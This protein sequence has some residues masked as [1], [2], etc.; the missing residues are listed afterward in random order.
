[1]QATGDRQ[2]A[3]K[4]YAV[5]VTMYADSI[6]DA[7]RRASGGGRVVHVCTNGDGTIL[8]APAGSIAID[9][10]RFER[11]IALAEQVRKT[12]EWTKVMLMLKPG[13][14]DPI[15]EQRVDFEY[16]EPMAVVDRA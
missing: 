2:M 5:V 1:M 9:R 12:E 11:L 16:V 15:P 8:S 13:D 4:M 10:A 14:L 3:M 6:E 7:K